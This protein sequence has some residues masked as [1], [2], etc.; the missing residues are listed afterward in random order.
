MQ[1]VPRQIKITGF[2]CGIEICQGHNDPLQ[3][4]G[5]DSARVVPLIEP[6]QPSVAERTNH[7]T[8][9]SC[10]GTHINQTAVS[11]AADLPVGKPG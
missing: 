8:I 7:T 2:V 5:G 3:L 10:T 4:V 9:V 11:L 1:S 6:P